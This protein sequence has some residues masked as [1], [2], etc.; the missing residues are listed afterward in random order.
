VLSELS[1]TEIQSEL[2]V[3]DTLQSGRWLK[4][5]VQPGKQVAIDEELLPKQG[6]QV[7]QVPAKDTLQLQALHQQDRDQRCSD[8]CL[9]GILRGPHEGF[10]LHGLLQGLEELF[11]LPALFVDRRD[12]GS[13]QPEIIGEEYHV[14]LLLL[15]PDLDA[16][17]AGFRANLLLTAQENHLIAENVLAF[18]HRTSFHDAVLHAVFQA[19][20]EVNLL[21]RQAQPPVVIRWPGAPG[22]ELL[23]C[24]NLLN[25][26]LST[27]AFLGQT[28]R[29]R[30][31]IRGTACHRTVHSGRAGGTAYPGTRP[32]IGLREWSPRSNTS[33]VSGAKVMRFAA[34]ISAVLPTVITA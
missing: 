12:R 20:D 11:D 19:G 14:F 13:R 16:A 27:P 7:G 22:T 8:L 10:D 15:H 33:I 23:V 17:Q 29:F 25:H 32:G 21:F 34:V 1:G 9:N 26:L 5:I 24:N 6:H 28:S 18:R 4:R 2:G 3:V 31:Q 30:R